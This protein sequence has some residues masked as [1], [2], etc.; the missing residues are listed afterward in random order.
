MKGILIIA[1]AVLIAS[2]CPKKE[3]TYRITYLDGT[4]E[5]VETRMRLKPV[6]GSDCWSS[7]FDDRYCGVRKVELIR[8]K[9]IK[10]ENRDVDRY[11]EPF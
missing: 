11:Q 5:S 4:T 3:Y 9:E 6:D 10:E 8:V 7:T 1:A 2:C